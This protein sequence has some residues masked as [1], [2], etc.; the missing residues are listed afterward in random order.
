[1]NS[2]LE[3]HTPGLVF[4]FSVLVQFQL[5]PSMSLRM[6]WLWDEGLGPGFQELVIGSIVLGAQYSARV[7]NCVASV[8]EDSAPSGLCDPAPLQMLP[9]DSL[10][11]LCGALSGPGCCEWLI[12]TVYVRGISNILSVLICS[13]TD[14]WVDAGLSTRPSG[15]SI[16]YFLVL[17]SLCVCVCSR[18]IWHFKSWK[19]NCKKSCL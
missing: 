15:S 17:A 10:P 8:T 12:H 6:H 4:Q 1:M 9:S 5:H 19:P 11:E 14:V 3:L 2:R 18:E 16:L 13:W 7:S